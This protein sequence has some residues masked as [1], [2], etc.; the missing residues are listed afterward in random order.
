[1]PTCSSSSIEN[2]VGRLRATRCALASDGAKCT[3]NAGRGCWMRSDGSARTQSDHMKRDTERAAVRSEVM[4][5]DKL[6]TERADKLAHER[7][8]GQ[9]SWPV[10]AQTFEVADFD[11]RRW[12]EREPE[13]QYYLERSSRPSR[14][15]DYDQEVDALLAAQLD[16]EQTVTRASYDV[17]LKRMLREEFESQLLVAA[18]EKREEEEEKQQ[19][20]LPDPRARVSLRAPTAE[21]LTWRAKAKAAEADII[22]CTIGYACSLRWLRPRPLLHRRLD[23][24]R[25]VDRARR[26]G[27]AACRNASRTQRASRPR[28]L[29]HVPVPVR[30]AA[31]GEDLECAQA[32]APRAR[33]CCPTKQ[34]PVQ[35]E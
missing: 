23:A 20:W 16:T 35:S 8:T 32:P 25:T 21:V 5:I 2:L 6:A 1:M 26:A 28:S 34:V 22:L 31:R 7:K 29:V 33:A 17:Q 13:W 14:P 24:G 27:C 19:P 12:M 10:L 4:R 30:L 18:Q 11:L 9:R 15:L 3:W